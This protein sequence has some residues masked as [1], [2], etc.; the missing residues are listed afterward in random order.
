MTYKV[1]ILS[2]R[3]SNL[4]PC[5][6]SVLAHEP[7]LPPR[8]I[9]VVDDGARAEAE[10]LLPGVRWITGVKPF[11]FARNANIGIA[12]AASDV[13]L[14]NDDARLVTERGFSMLVEQARLRA[15]LALCSAGIRGAVGNQRQIASGKSTFRSEDRTLAFVCVYIPQWAFE[16]LGPLDERFTGYGFEDNDYCARARAAGLE[17]GIW[18]GCIVDHTGELSSTFRTRSDLSKL[19]NQNR[20]LFAEK[21]RNG[22]STTRRAPSAPVGHKQ[23]AE[24]VS[25]RCVDMLYLACNRLEFTRETFGALITNTDWQ[26]VRELVV[27]DDGSRDGTREWLGANISKVPAPSRF[28]R[29]RFGSPV[30]AMTHFIESAAAPILAKS[31][32]DAMLPPRWLSQSLAV[33]DS[34]S[35]LTMLGIEAMYPHDDDPTTT[36]SYTR[37]QFISGLGLYRRE[38][39]ARSRPSA[40]GKWF[41]LEEW[42]T[43]HSREFIYGWI[44][45]ALPVFLL[46]RFPFEPWIG[47]SNEYIRRGWQRSWPKYDPDCTLWRWRFS[48]SPFGEAVT[49]SGDRRFLCAMRIKN[50]AARIHEVLTRSLKLCE[51]TYIFDDHSTD[52]TVEICRS[53]GERVTLFHSPFEGL[54][55]ARD[56]NYLLGKIIEARPEWV[57]WIDGDEALEQ[58][59]PQRIKEAALASNRVAAY[60]LRI[61]YLWNDPQHIRV[62]GIFGRFR[63][64][65]LF[66]LS[67]QA[68][69]R[70]HFPATGFGGNFHC[71]NVPRGLVG[72]YRNLDVRLKHYG[73][74]LPDI[75]QAKYEWYNQIDPNNAAED[76]Y[77]HLIETPGARH[78]PGPPRIV[79]WRE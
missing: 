79:A 42:Q 8:D 59:G 18:D 30:K 22:N 2:A 25:E 74:M 23:T 12:E 33:I 56:K 70:L 68:A 26:Y 61:S 13:I 37:A 55:E 65:S 58:S 46:D 31:D 7:D 28:L 32:N 3:A 10:P 75:R 17:L 24:V 29:T 5:V 51:R 63:R 20:R 64:P 40:Y 60:Q 62:D 45:P 9:I 34:H 21:W 47:Y 71:G 57:L 11:V 50:E 53:F 76:C 69:S 14:L 73:L 4:V 1:V 48:E 77:R 41:G 38:A 44:T 43:S 36:R 66:R 6:Q 35:E 52:D 27:I 78:A 72:G 67:G 49:E 16:K 19:F 54:D 15:N 39:F